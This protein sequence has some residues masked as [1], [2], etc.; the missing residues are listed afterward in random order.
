MSRAIASRSTTL[1]NR[2]MGR[3]VVK[4]QDKTG[5]VKYQ[6]LNSGSK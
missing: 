6:A 5:T 2:M 4:K 3:I 1:R